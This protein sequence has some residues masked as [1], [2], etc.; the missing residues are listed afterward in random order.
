MLKSL[1][2]LLIFVCAGASAGMPSVAGNRELP[3]VADRSGVTQQ[4]VIFLEPNY[5]TLRIDFVFSV[6]E[7]CAE[8]PVLEGR[9]RPYYLYG[10][11]LNAEGLQVGRYIAHGV[12]RDKAGANVT[13]YELYIKGLPKIVY[14]MEAEPLV[15]G[16]HI[17]GQFKDFTFYQLDPSPI[18][19]PD[20]VWGLGWRIVLTLGE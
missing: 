12:L 3:G 13:D 9:P 10:R 5:S 8:W 6:H 2:L 20:C 14:G 16:Y 18:I 1:L 4:R 7:V 15:D 17:D 11:I 19:E